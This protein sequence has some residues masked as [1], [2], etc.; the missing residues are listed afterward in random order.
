MYNGRKQLFK[1]TIQY[2][3]FNIGKNYIAFITN[4]RLDK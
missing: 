4:E 2:K 3:Q 1:E